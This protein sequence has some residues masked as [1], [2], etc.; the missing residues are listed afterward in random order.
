MTYGEIYHDFSR[1]AKK[2]ELRYKVSEG[3]MNSAVAAIQKW[4]H[5]LRGRPF[6]LHS[7]SSVV[8]HVLKNYKNTSKVLGRLASDIQGMCFK[9]KHIST[10]TNPTDYF[11][12]LVFNEQRVCDTHKEDTNIPYLDGNGTVEQR[13]EP[14][15]T[16]YYD[17]DNMDNEVA[18]EEDDQDNKDEVIDRHTIVA[19]INEAIQKIQTTMMQY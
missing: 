8:Y 6:I 4:Q 9:V 17:G 1:L 14:F 7:D 16:D 11:T 15:E 3:E 19:S 12:R 18:D 2:A 5:Y 10:K 13:Q